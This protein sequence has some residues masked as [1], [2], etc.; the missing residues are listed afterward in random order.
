M[1]ALSIDAADVGPEQFVSMVEKDLA[2][3]RLTSAAIE[4]ATE[5]SYAEK[6]AAV[7][8]SL[9]SGL[10]AEG[11]PDVDRE[12]LVIEALRDMEP[13]HVWLLD[14]LVQWQPLTGSL[15]NGSSGP[16]GEAIA[17]GPAFTPTSET[18]R[19]PWTRSELAA[20][21]NRH[22]NHAVFE[23][24]LGALLR[25]GLV[26]ED[27]TEPLQALSSSSRFPHRD[28]DLQVHVEPSAFGLDVHALLLS[29]EAI[30]EVELGHLDVDGA[31]R[32]A[33]FLPG[34]AQLTPHAAALGMSVADAQALEAVNDAPGPRGGTR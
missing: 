19:T 5:A 31:A 28:S 29:S 23:P 14:R 2:T 22:Q 9:A 17:L 8:R 15:L 3:E 20:G 30:Q 34:W 25:H 27:A 24:A 18:R 21:F 32:G 16:H 7:A 12:I 13:V 11:R 26:V 10:S 1:L 4:A 6:L 33:R